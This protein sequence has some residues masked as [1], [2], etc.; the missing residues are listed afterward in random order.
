MLSAACVRI[1]DAERGERLAALRA[2]LASVTGAAAP[3]GELAQRV[4][5]E[6]THY[7]PL[8]AAHYPLLTTH[9]SLLTAHSLFTTRSPLTTHDSLL[10]THQVLLRP[11]LRGI[12]DTYETCREISAAA[13]L[14]TCKIGGDSSKSLALAVPVVSGRLCYDTTQL[15]GSNPK[16]SAEE[17]RCHIYI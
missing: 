12:S 7:S 3:Q 6:V 13:L 5:I 9:C 11:L 4:W 8:L 16:E 17:V 1:V 14:N 2:V 10:T 15:G